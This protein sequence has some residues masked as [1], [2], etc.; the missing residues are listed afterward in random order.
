MTVHVSDLL[1][2]PLVAATPDTSI[3]DAARIMTGHRVSAPIF[4]EGEGLAG[5]ITDRD[6]HSR[7][8]AAGLPYTTPVREIMTENLHPTG[9]DT[10]GFQVLTAMTRLNVHHLPELNAGR[11]VG[12]VSTSDLV[13]FQS[14]NAVYLAGDIHKGGQRRDRCLHRPPAEAG[15]GGSS[16]RPRYLMPGWRVAPRCAA[17][18]HPTPIR[19]TPC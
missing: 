3:R 15:G 13:R 8:I 18:N 12:V 5:M 7:C 9:A 11:V 17:S 4:M 10:L 16:A 6:L 19:T 14:A 2:R 1:S